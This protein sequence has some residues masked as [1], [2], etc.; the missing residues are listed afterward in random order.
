MSKLEELLYRGIGSLDF[1][2]SKLEELVQSL[3]EEGE[4]TKKQGKELIERWQQK[5]DKQKDKLEDIFDAK[6]DALGVVRVEELDKLKERVARLES[7][8]RNINDESY[9]KNNEI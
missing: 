4:L 2:V 9:Q 3:V 6:L 7:E 1:T 8:L 5:S